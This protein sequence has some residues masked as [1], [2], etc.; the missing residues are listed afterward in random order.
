ML[1]EVTAENTRDEVVLDGGAVLIDTLESGR[2]GQLT[3]SS[4]ESSTIIARV[5]GS[6]DL[7]ADGIEVRHHPLDGAVALD[8]LHNLVTNAY[9]ET[10]ERVDTTGDKG[11]AVRLHLETY[12]RPLHIQPAGLECRDRNHDLIVSVHGRKSS[13]ARRVNGERLVLLGSEA[14]KALHLWHQADNLLGNRCTR[15]LCCNIDLQNYSLGRVSDR[16]S[17]V[18]LCLEELLRVRGFDD[19]LKGQ[20]QIKITTLVVIEERPDL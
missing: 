14:T 8:I 17:F 18:C 10:V 9:L 3:T 13:R 15:H 16:V 19:S 1:L 6:R 7:L 12:V 2:I 5:V 11:S 4:S 20:H